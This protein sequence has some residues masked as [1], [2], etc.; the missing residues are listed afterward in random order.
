L[1]VGVEAAERKR[2]MTFADLMIS[3]KLEVQKVKPKSSENPKNFF[4]FPRLSL[5]SFHE[6][7]MKLIMQ[8][9]CQS[10]INLISIPFRKQSEA[11][12]RKK[13]ESRK[14]FQ[15]KFPSPHFHI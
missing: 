13:D 5:K 11:S 3:E 14:S 7:Q 6:L 4:D 10:R 8:K 2:L 9:L 1:S 15:R 12:S